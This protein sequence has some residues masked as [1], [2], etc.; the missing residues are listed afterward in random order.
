MKIN[1][2]LVDATMM[3][4]FIILVLVGTTDFSNMLIKEITMGGLALLSIAMIVLRIIGMRQEASSSHGEY[5][6]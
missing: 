5:E 6:Y 4:S 3:L 1:K 2:D